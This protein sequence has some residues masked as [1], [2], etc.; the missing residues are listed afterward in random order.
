MPPLAIKTA[1]AP[2]D[3]TLGKYFPDPQD[4][5]S[6]DLLFPKKLNDAVIASVDTGLVLASQHPE[7]VEVFTVLKQSGISDELGH[8][9]L[10]EMLERNPARNPE[11]VNYKDSV[12]HAIERLFGL[13]F[14][15]DLAGLNLIFFFRFVHFLGDEFGEQLAGVWDDIGEG[16]SVG[17]VAMAFREPNDPTGEVYVLEAGCTDFSHYRVTISPYFDPDD[18]ARV[19]GQ[20]RSWAARRIA[21]DE[22]IWSRRLVRA[23]HPV[24]LSA[25]E[26]Q[27]LV[28][29]CK[30]WLGVPYGILEPGMMD[31]PERLYCSELIARAVQTLHPKVDIAQNQNWRWVIVNLAKLGNMGPVID[32]IT[33]LMAAPMGLAPFPILSPKMLYAS[34]SLAQQFSPQGRSYL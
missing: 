1:T 9:F 24:A 4:L 7:V 34:A 3:M 8:Q 33:D 26:Q 28:D 23:R 20:H 13:K 27:G 19:K 32:L 14:L 17:H 11:L 10:L 15:Q 12:D 6:G 2:L 29:E 30:H 18:R 16:Y 21:L 25:Q 5:Q 31:N 22:A